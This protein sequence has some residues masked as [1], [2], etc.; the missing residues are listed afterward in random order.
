MKEREH[1]MQSILVKEQ[2]ALEERE[3]LKEAG[4]NS[5]LYSLMRPEGM[6]AV[7]PDSTGKNLVLLPRVRTQT[8]EERIL[9]ILRSPEEKKSAAFLI[10]CI[11]VFIS[12]FPNLDSCCSKN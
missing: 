2:V 3:L 4:N 5:V 9:Q 10:A 7:L 8:P 1:L 12:L 11:L 6:E